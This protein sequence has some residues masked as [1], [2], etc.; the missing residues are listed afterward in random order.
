M[1]VIHLHSRR[2]RHGA[3]RRRDA[4]HA[5]NDAMHSVFA[6]LDLWLW[7]R[8]ERDQLATLSDRMLKDIGL[9]HADR[10]FLVN[11]PFWRE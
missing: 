11:K 10:D 2:D 1:S 6:T 5:L 4:L 7:R 8:R 3:V 9:T